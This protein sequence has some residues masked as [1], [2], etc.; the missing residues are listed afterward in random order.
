[1][2]QSH[3]VAFAAN[4]AILARALKIAVRIPVSHPLNLSQ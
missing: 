1:M 3:L 2:I 4:P